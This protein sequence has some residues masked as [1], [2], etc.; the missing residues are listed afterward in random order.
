MARKMNQTLWDGWRRRIQQQS[1]SGRS[2]ADFCRSEGI[3]QGSFYLW[4]RKLQSGSP[5]ERSPRSRRKSPAAAS[6]G[7][8]RQGQ[9]TDRT[10]RLTETSPSGVTGFLELPVVAARP[11]P[12]IELVLADGTIL[13]V[14]HQSTAALLSVLRVLR[15]EHLD[16][17]H[18][19]G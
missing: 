7:G 2:I 11:N 1:Q 9:A 12:W 8:V 3:S 15:G 17:L 19:E 16:P 6:R 5:R 4:K 13:R 18:A 14:P 10:G